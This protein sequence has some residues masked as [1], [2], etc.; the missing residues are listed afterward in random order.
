MSQNRKIAF[1]LLLAA[2][3]GG[4]YY[5]GSQKA[6]PAGSSAAEEIVNI[7]ANSERVAEKEKKYE[8]AKEITTPDG[9]LNIDKIALK[10]LVG[11][12]VVLVDFW[13]Y[14]CINCQ[15]TQ[16]YLNAWY[17][18]YREQG[19]EIVGI[20][21]PEFEFEKKY[22]NVREAV[23]QAGIEYPVVLDNDFS[24]W[25]AY[26]NQYWPRKYLI[27]IDGLIIYDHAGEGAYEE[28]ERKI[29]EALSE[30]AVVLERQEEISKDISKPE[31]VV[32]VGFSQG[33]SPEVYFGADRNEFLANG[34]SSQEGE[35]DFLE[36]ASPAPNQLYLA[37]RWDIT[38][39][40]AENKSKGAKII[41]RYRAKDVYFVAGAEKPVNMRVL[42]DG[43]FIQNITIS[44]F[45]RYTVI[46]GD[47]YGEH[48]LELIPET[49]GLQ[50]HTFTFGS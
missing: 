28:T 45:K 39:E 42:R 20:H 6:R 30:R 10:E 5:F 17:K 8:R 3:A 26:R 13:T 29:Q 32:E 4:I 22:E 19:L 25:R 1:I 40:Y 24:T 37:G 21:T 46:D 36:F 2:I 11:K 34:K 14:S 16:P 35:Q 41:F 38:K 49:P 9:F 12:K 47:S 31:G 33:Q 50:A 43:Q 23:R 27:D 48:T 15:R 44:G 18:K 7:Q